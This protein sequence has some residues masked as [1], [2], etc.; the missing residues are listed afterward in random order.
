[1]PY[2]FYHYCSVVQLEVR[3]GDSPRSSF[4]VENSFHYPGFFVIPNELQILTLELYEEKKEAKKKKELYEELICNFD[5]N[6]IESVD[7]FQKDGQFL[8]Y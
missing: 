8:L 7:C 1:M 3:H 4:I 2:N 5:G 6:C